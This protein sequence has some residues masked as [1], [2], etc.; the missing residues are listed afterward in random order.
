MNFKKSQLFKLYFNLMKIVLIFSAVLIIRM[1]LDGLALFGLSVI[2]IQFYA[3]VKAQ[4]FI[5][6]RKYL[7]ISI[8]LILSL[9]CL[10]G[11]TLPLGLLGFY[12][13]LNKEFLNAYKPKDAPSWFETNITNSTVFNF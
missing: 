1:Q 9:L 6:E 12:C 11:M 2:G 5:E 7:G 13:F 8:G 3:V 10:G 4:K